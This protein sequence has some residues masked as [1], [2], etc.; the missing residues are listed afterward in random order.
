MVKQEIKK[1]LGYRSISGTDYF[2]VSWSDMSQTW[3]PSNNI[4]ALKE[5]NLFI[6]KLKEY[7]RE[8]LA[9]VVKEKRKAEERKI[10]LELQSMKR[11]ENVSFNI[12]SFIDKPKSD[13]KKKENL[14]RQIS[15]K[16]S[17]MR[18][19]E[20]PKSSF[21]KNQVQSISKFSNS[22]RYFE[23][24]K[25]IVLEKKIIETPKPF[26]AP[27]DSFIMS[28]ENNY[29]AN[30]HIKNGSSNLIKKPPTKMKICFYIEIAD[31]YSLLF[32]SLQN[33][34]LQKY[35]Y[36]NL[37]LHNS[38]P[39]FSEFNEE[40]SKNKKAF[41]DIE[42]DINV[43]YI[44]FYHEKAFKKYDIHGFYNLLVFEKKYFIET[45]MFKNMKK[46]QNDEFLIWNK[47]SA[48]FESMV[49]DL[50][51]F[52]LYEYNLSPIFKFSIFSNDSSEV[53]QY[54]SSFLKRRGCEQIS[55]LE[56]STSIIFINKDYISY[57]NTIPNLIYHKKN[58][59]RFFVF[60]TSKC[61]LNF[62]PIY[63]IFK[64]G[65]V[66]TI[67]R[68]LLF[69][70]NVS[71]LLDV[72][73]YSNEHPDKCLLRVPGQLV[74]DFKLKLNESSTSLS[75]SAYSNIFEIIKNSVENISCSSIEEYL[76]CLELKYQ[77]QRRF[78][79]ILNETNTGYFIVTPT[80]FY[81]NYIKKD[82]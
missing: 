81:D 58:R 74:S 39:K 26:L 35:D 41:V 25:P 46:I 57:V 60:D 9:E 23:I 68:S 10:L 33:K 19:K 62:P 13:I 53:M 76:T 70:V 80:A 37:L 49:E 4:S 54:F 75:F 36:F 1:I 38:D 47:N 82:N 44:F 55:S 18:K 51:I 30:F 56:K 6:Y 3:E 40:I 16:N 2:L 77:T 21:V 61:D 52:N 14:E 28:Y 32:S 15:T 71:G 29:I 12:T 64:R 42:T 34:K 17:N 65:C 11:V 66:I 48:I 43:A 72:L 20:P 5:I 50:I 69:N 22:R 73:N 63:E 67:T 59:S 78:F 7:Q 79:F 31:I 24:E 8:L 27:K 45:K